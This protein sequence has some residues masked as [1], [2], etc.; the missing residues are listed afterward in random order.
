MME[1]QIG[2][3]SGTESPRLAIVYDGKT[4][5]YGQPGSVPKSVSRKHCLVTVGEDP[6]P[7]PTPGPAVTGVT[8]D[9]DALSIAPGAAS[10]CTSFSL[11]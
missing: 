3:E 9:K 11:R 8:L 4:N 2:R 5:Y 1:L 7:G 6:A 10:T